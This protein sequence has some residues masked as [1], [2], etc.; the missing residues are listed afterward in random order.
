MEIIWTGSSWPEAICEWNCDS[1]FHKVEESCVENSVCNYPEN[2]CKEIN[3]T[4]CTV[5]G[6]AAEG[7]TCSC[8]PGFIENS[9]GE[10]SPLF[11][12]NCDESGTMPVIT[13]SITIEGDTSIEGITNDLTDQPSNDILY[14]LVF[15]KKMNLRVTVTADFDAVLYF[16]DTCGTQE[17]KVDTSGVETY[18]S[19][20][21]AGTYFIMVDGYSSY[22]KGKFTMEVNL[23]EDPCAQANPCTSAHQGVCTDDDLDGIAEC[24]CDTDFHMENNTCVSDTKQVQCADNAPENATANIVDVDVTW[25]GSTWAEPVECSWNCNTGFHEENGICAANDACHSPANPCTETNRT[26]C[27]LDETAP[28]GFL[29]Q[30]DQGL[31]EDENG[32]CISTWRDNCEEKRYDACNHGIRNL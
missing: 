23:V 18:T 4:T 7:Y 5:D 14:K 11:R 13:S 8:S 25:N 3:R 22:N 15:D 9:N 12:N 2:P 19:A 21:E 20:V 27:Q 10:C 17:N 16:S 24:G 30:C 26:S 32:A 31:F 28:E 29:C 6:A 1:G